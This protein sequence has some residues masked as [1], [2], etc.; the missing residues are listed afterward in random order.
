[1][2]TRRFPTVMTSGRLCSRGRARGLHGAKFP[3]LS[4]TEYGVH[5]RRLEAV[6][7]L[8][9]HGIQHP[10]RHEIADHSAAVQAHLAS[11]RCASMPRT[12]SLRVLK[13]GMCARLPASEILALK[14]RCVGPEFFSEVPATDRLG[15]QR[16]R[17][18][19]F[20][21]HSPGQWP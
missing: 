15:S 20:T 4:K 14:S 21:V 9:Y 18:E 1:M 7:A 19:N 16:K 5:E 10:G 8:A 11:T 17:K 13:N 2:R 3:G 6:S 12:G